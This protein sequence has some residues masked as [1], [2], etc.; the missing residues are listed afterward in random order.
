L[1]PRSS[2][3]SLKEVALSRLLLVAGPH[4]LGFPVFLIPPRSH[5][6]QPPSPSPP[7]VRSASVQAP[8]WL[9]LPAGCR[10]TCHGR[11]PGGVGG[12][13]PH[14]IEDGGT[15]G[16]ASPAAAGPLIVPPI[17]DLPCHTPHQ[18]VALYLFPLLIS[19][20]REGIRR[21]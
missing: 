9:Q 20:G 10:A 15:E 21:C 13:R 17:G 5:L 6:F 8:Q 16:N 4:A 12:R 3:R 14:S 11:R 1:A 18:S 7:G 19:K 2:S